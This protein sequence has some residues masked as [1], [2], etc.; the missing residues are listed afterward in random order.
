MVVPLPQSGG[1]P[2]GDAALIAWVGQLLDA[3]FPLPPKAE[4][5]A[6]DS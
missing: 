4:P 5:G 1:E 3:L 6:K 2:L